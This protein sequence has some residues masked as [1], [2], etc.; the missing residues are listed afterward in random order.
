MF[1]KLKPKILV[2]LSTFKT[3]IALAPTSASPATTSPFRLATAL[4]S[5]TATPQATAAPPAPATTPT[6]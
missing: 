4:T 3:I 6:A 5:L 2:P 1:Q